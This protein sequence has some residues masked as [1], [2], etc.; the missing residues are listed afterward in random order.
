ML[1][2]RAADFYE[3][4]DDKQIVGKHFKINMTYI[5]IPIISVYSLY[6]EVIFFFKFKHHYKSMKTIGMCRN[7]YE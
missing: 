7:V 5:N 4:V 1:L 6:I 3:S 2:L